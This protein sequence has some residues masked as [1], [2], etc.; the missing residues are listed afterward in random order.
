[1]YIYIYINNGRRKIAITISLEKHKLVNK[2]SELI[3]KCKHKNK[4][5]L[6]HLKINDSDN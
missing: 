5:L 6:N 3:S 2:G 1:M 4:F